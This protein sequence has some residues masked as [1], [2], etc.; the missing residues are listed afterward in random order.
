MNPTH[1]PKFAFLM[2]AEAREPNPY[3]NGEPLVER[4]GNFYGGF[5]EGRENEHVR[6]ARWTRELTKFMTMALSLKPQ[7]FK[8]QLK[9]DV[10]EWFGND[11]SD[12]LFN[13]VYKQIFETKRGRRPQD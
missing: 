5:A 1:K 9:H 7:P 4:A 13:A 3:G 11:I 10:R 2:F 8:K 12:R 6:R